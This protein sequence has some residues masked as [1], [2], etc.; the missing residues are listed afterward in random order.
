[1]LDN[2]QRLTIPEGTGSA[3]SN[4]QGTHAWSIGKSKGSREEVF[5]RETMREENSIIH[6]VVE[7]Y[8]KAYI[9]RK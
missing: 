2:T 4:T 5:Y 6:T 7:L 1:M 3:R 9:K 8:R